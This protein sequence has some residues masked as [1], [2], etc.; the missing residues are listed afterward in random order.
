[1]SKKHKKKDEEI[2]FEDE[3]ET[4]KDKIK[5]IKDELKKVK[6]ER[7]EYLDGWQRSRA[8]YAN[9]K[10]ETEDGRSRLAEIIQ[11]GTLES[12]LPVLDS[13][14]MAFSNK[15]TWEAV[16]K[17]WRIGVEYIYNQMKSVMKEYGL[18]EINQIEVDFDPEIHQALETK[19]SENK[20]D[21]H[22]V[23]KIVQKG[24]KKGANVIRPAKVI[25]YKFK[26]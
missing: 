19:D 23:A 15:E 1:M 14:D 25:I 24:Y 18:E 12:F 21:D 7:Q 2:I 9:F 17:N 4:S 22:K 3:N 8:E 11:T 5:K 6:E 10:K 26:N 20:D 16:D 13:F